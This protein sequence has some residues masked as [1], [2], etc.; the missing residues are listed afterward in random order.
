M[1][2]W[3]TIGCTDRS[4]GTWGQHARISARAVVSYVSVHNYIT[5]S[6]CREMDLASLAEHTPSHK[7]RVTMH[8]LEPNVD[9]PHLC[10]IAG[11]GDYVSPAKG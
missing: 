3:R 4:P 1:Y 2:L 9:S 7:D 11:T 10:T 6:I 5:R 8:S